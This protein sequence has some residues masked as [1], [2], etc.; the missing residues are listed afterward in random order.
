[1]KADYLQDECLH[2]QPIS[3]KRTNTKIDKSV[4]LF[5]CD[6]KIQEKKNDC[7]QNN[8]KQIVLPE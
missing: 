2:N 8:I 7:K 3:T 1:M 6:H 4:K 5:A